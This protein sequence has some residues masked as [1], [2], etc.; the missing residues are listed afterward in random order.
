MISISIACRRYLGWVFPL[1]FSSACGTGTAWKVELSSTLPVPQADCRRYLGQVF[2]LKKICLGHVPG[3]VPGTTAGTFTVI[4]EP[5]LMVPDLKTF[6]DNF[7]GACWELTQQLDLSTCW[8]KTMAHWSIFDDTI[9]RWKALP[10][11]ISLAKTCQL[12]KNSRVR[13]TSFYLK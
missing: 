7:A 6:W 5:G 4:W 13:N 12:D 10:C 3:S 9:L 8:L 1:K 2:P 11:D